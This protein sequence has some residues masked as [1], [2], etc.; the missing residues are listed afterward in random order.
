VEHQSA[1]SI[2]DPG[3]VYVQTRSRCYQITIIEPGPFNTRIINEHLT[4]LPPHPAYTDPRLGTN[5]SRAWMTPAKL[6]PMAGKVTKGAALFYRLSTLDNPPFRLPLHPRV[7][8]RAK[9][10]IQT[11]QAGVDGY[12]SWSEEIF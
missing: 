5:L 6:Y 11:L 2:L 9:H 1:S 3:I 8:D 7:L 12:A 10:H 4:I